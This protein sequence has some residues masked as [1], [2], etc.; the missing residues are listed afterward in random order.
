MQQLLPMRYRQC[1]CI[2]II[3]QVYKEAGALVC[4]NEKDK[5]WLSLLEIQRQSKEMS[6]VTG[7]NVPLNHVVEQ[8]PE[9]QLLSRSKAALGTTNHSSHLQQRNTPQR[10]AKAWRET[11]YNNAFHVNLLWELPEIFI[12]SDE[13]MKYTIVTCPS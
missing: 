4:H 5:M 8:Y 7:T 6:A 12:M 2:I 11:S 9:Q 10:S 1:F 13:K 3:L